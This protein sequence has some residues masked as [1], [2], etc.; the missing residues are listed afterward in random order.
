MSAEWLEPINTTPPSLFAMRCARRRAKAR[1]KISL[2]SASVWTM[3]RSCAKSI[4]STSVASRAR[5]PTRLWRPDIMSTSPVNSP[6]AWIVMRSSPSRAGL[7][8]STRPSSST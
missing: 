4:S 1:R 8:I 3:C 6:A 5:A 2:S 7:A